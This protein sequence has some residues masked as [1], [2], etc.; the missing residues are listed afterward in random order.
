MHVRCGKK[1]NALKAH[2]CYIKTNNFVKYIGDRVFNTSNKHKY[3]LI[4]F[5]TCSFYIPA[6]YIMA[7]HAFALDM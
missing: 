3:V 2:N 7:L 5:I 4:T 6:Q 1:S